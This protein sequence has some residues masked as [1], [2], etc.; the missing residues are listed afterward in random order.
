MARSIL[1]NMKRA[2]IALLMCLCLPLVGAD[3]EKPLPKDIPSLKVLV[4]KGDARAQN[5]LGRMYTKGQGVKQDHAEAVKRYRKA[6]L[7]GDAGAQY[8]LGVMYDIGEGVKQDFKE[9]MKWYR[10]AGEQGDAYGQYNLGR[11]YSKGQGV[12]HDDVTAYAWWNIAALSG[13]VGAKKFKGILAKK[14]TPKQIAKAEALVKM[15]LKR[16]PKLLKSD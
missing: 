2:L 15:M 13:H 6:A 16:N 8:D 7:Q 10:K 9:A 12:P 5:E 1:R 4:E 11:M 14:M 3:K